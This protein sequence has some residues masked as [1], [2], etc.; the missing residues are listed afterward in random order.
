MILGSLDAL[1]NRLS[2]DAE[3][4]VAPRGYSQQKISFKVVLT[5]QGD[6]FEI[7]DAREPVEGAMRP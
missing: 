2:A 3:Y 5:P 4:N 6:L 7:Q 1:Y